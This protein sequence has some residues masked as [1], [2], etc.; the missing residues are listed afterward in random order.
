MLVRDSCRNRAQMGISATLVRM[1]EQEST[2]DEKSFHDFASRRDAYKLG[3]V[4]EVKKKFR[5]R[6]VMLS[7]LPAIAGLEQT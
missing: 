5:L 4:F 6:N 2:R 3:D 7:E 1:A